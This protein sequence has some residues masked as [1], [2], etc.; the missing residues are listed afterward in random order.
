MGI[1][2]MG[3]QSN[4]ILNAVVLPTVKRKGKEREGEGR[5]AKKGKKRKKRRKER[6]KEKQ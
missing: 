6:R 4:F 5:E 1:V 2:A 3:L